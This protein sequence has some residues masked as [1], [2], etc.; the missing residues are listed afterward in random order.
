M[1]KLCGN[2]YVCYKINK[3]QSQLIKS[4]NCSICLSVTEPILQWK[5]TETRQLEK[6]YCRFK[7]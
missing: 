2:I 4:N 7:C 6:V 1:W 5:K 3:M